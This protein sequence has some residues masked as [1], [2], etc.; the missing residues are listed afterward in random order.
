[1]EGSSGS[2]GPTGTTTYKA[3]NVVVTRTGS[4]SAC[5]FGSHILYRDTPHDSYNL[6]ILPWLASTQQSI[7]LVYITCP[8]PVNVLLRFYE[9]TWWP[10]V[11]SSNQNNLRST[12]DFHN[13]V[14]TDP[15]SNNMGSIRPKLSLNQIL[16]RS[17]GFLWPWKF[18]CVFQWSTEKH[19][20]IWRWPFP[21]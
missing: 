19:C 5:S 13:R 2:P 3:R 10:L 7:S 16:R 6:K 11:Q 20:G 9:M 4:W 14:A 17:H 12:D 21:F 15:C 18:P 1:M 8:T